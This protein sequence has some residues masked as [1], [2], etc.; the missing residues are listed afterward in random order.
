L[1]REKDASPLVLLLPALEP[2][3]DVEVPCEPVCEPLP[4]PS[5]LPDV[6]WPEF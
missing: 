3:P 1:P 5:P 6:D 4:A 2:Y